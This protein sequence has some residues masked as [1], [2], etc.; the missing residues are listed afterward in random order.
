MKASERGTDGAEASIERP[1]FSQAEQRRYRLPAGA[2]LE[3]REERSMTR[4][5]V[6]RDW[7]VAGLGAG[8]VSGILV[9]VFAAFAAKRAGLPFTTP[10]RFIASAV[11]GTGGGE[12]HAAPAYGLIF[13]LIAAILWAFGYI[14][15]SQKQSQLLTRPILSGVGFGVIVWLFSQAILVGAGKFSAPTIYT[16]DRD[17]VA[18]IIFFGVPLAFTAS[19]LL[20]AR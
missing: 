10:Y 15:G 11:L 8:L 16:F 5:L 19:R 12:G 14:Y 17:M 13:L 20:R 4:P 2:M 9:A 1:F 3:A 6:L 7:L 18:F